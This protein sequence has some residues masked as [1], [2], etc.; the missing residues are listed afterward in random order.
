MGIDPSV[1]ACGIAVHSISSKKLV[2]H[3]LLK[4]LNKTTDAS[5]KAYSITKQ[6]YKLVIKYNVSVVVLEVPTYWSIAGFIARESGSIFKLTFLCG[7]VCGRLIKIVKMII[8]NPGQYK[9]QLTKT[10]VAN[11]L[12]KEPMYKHIDIHKLNHNVCDA[13][14][15]G[16]WYLH[17]KLK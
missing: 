2:H 8:V 4:P 14:Y 5:Y 9:G 1:N 10:V 7:M 13:I 11:R 12:A 16:F 6:I 3:E 15:I 17:K